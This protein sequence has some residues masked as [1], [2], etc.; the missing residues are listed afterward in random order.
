MEKASTALAVMQALAPLIPIPVVS[1]IVD[2]AG[3]V[4]SAAKVCCFLI[5]GK[6]LFME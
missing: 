3:M 5:Y 4:V 1:S 2:S 6:L